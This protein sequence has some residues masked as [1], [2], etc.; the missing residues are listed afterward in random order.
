MGNNFESD[1]KYNNEKDI[2]MQ[3]NIEK[4]CF[5]KGENIIGNI[6]LKLKEGL[7]TSLIEPKVIFKIDENH[8]YYQDLGLK[9]IQ[10]SEQYNIL[11]ETIMFNKFQGAN[12]MEQVKIP[13]KIEVPEKAYPSCIFAKS[14]YVRHYFSVEIPSIQAKKTKIIIV[15]NNRYFSKENK[16]LISPALYYKEFQKKSFLSNKGSFTATL[17]IP[18]NIFPYDRKIPFE[19]EI[20]CSNLKMDLFRVVVCLHRIAQKNDK[21]NHLRTFI[22][23]EKLI[24]SKEIML[25][26]GLKNYHIEDDIKL[27]SN[28]LR[29]NPKNVYIMLDNDKRNFEEKFADIELYPSCFGGIM[30]CYYFISMF[31]QTDLFTAEDPLKIPIDFYEP[32]TKET[33]GND[34]DNEGNKFY[35]INK[36]DSPRE[37]IS[38]K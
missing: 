13:F 17:K 27:V 16:L 9:F 20:D 1:K 10:A 32:F 34:D 11:T 33:F 29:D 21:K 8:Q 23:D 2:S 5:S 31:I 24:S 30:S 26:K 3:L 38:V 37:L 6:I 12:L 35:D 18:Y 36:C 15:K 4:T 19:I 22:S 7:Q 25:I 14:S 28:D